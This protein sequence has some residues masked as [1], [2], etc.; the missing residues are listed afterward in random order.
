MR[1]TS[2]SKGQRGLGKRM[3][4]LIAAVFVVAGCL[5]QDYK[6]I[7]LSLN[8]WSSGWQ[9]TV[10]PDERFDVFL[11][12]VRV[13]P[14]ARW[15]LVAADPSVVELA[16]QSVVEAEAVPEEPGEWV[17]TFRAVALGGS[18]LT[19]EALAGGA[20]V[21]IAEYSVSVV[22][23]ACAA[24]VG[25]TAARCRAPVSTSSRGW[26]EWD[27]GRTVRVGMNRPTELTL[28]APAL[29]PAARWRPADVDTPLLEV[30][31]ASVGAVRSP[32]DFDNQDASK[33]DS[34]LPVWSYPVQGLALGQTDLAF[35]AVEAGE[36]VDIARFT[37]RV[38]ESVEEGEYLIQADDQR[39][40]AAASAV[41]LGEM[42]QASGRPLRLFAAD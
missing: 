22:E 1:G 16:D 34:F 30:G 29:F 3:G 5:G 24:G 21:A 23:D 14:D 15:R 19:F 10:E 32:G 11:G 27:H 7:E 33:P 8:E 36:R 37:V 20:R 35:E 13:H 28:T 31:S 4:V 26:T 42:R 41:T 39:G 12:P 25:L 40:P 2:R 18:P 9:A 38:L 17:F 6:S